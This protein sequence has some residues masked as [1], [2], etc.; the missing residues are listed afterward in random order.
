MTG[1]QTCALPI[2]AD[3]AGVALG[4]GGVPSARDAGPPPPDAGPPPPDGGSA[5]PDAASAPESVTYQAETMELDGYV[6]DPADETVIRLPE[7]VPRGTARVRF[8]GVPGDYRLTVRAVAEP[9]GEP[10]LTL[11]VGDA[12]VQTVTYPPA[13]GADNE[14]ISLGPYPVRLAADEVLA[15]EGE[16]NEGAWARVDAVELAP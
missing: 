15:L 8:D 10:T 5:P 16:A 1:V 9:D 12:V 3:L 11:R 2:L 6:V 14:P 4:E 7:A 13:S